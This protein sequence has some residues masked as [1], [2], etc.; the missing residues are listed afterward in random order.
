MRKH[1]IILGCIL[2]AQLFTPV[3][4]TAYYELLRKPALLARGATGC[5]TYEPQLRQEM[6]RDCD[7]AIRSYAGDIVEELYIAKYGVT[8]TVVRA[9]NGHWLSTSKSYTLTKLLLVFPAAAFLLAPIAMVHKMLRTGAFWSWELARHPAD[10][11]ERMLQFYL[12]PVM[13]LGIGM[14]GLAQFVV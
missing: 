8:S 11:F 12:A 9:R 13:L 5:D 1:R 7:I 4:A 10:Q 14:V 2:C 3:L 6:P